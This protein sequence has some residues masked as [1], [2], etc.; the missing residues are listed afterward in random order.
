MLRKRSGFTLIELLVVIAIIAILIAL[1]VPAVQKV[2]EAAARTQCT[3]N[4]KQMGL[5]A[6]SCH[7]AY[8]HFPPAL[9]TMGSSSVPVANQAW[10]NAIFHMLPFIDQGNLYQQSFGTVAAFGFSCY[11]A[12]NNNVYAQVV[13]VF[14]CPSDPSQ[15]GGQVTFTINGTAYQFGACSYGFNSLIFSGNNNITY[16]VPP[17]QP[18]LVTANGYNP[19]GA[20][21]MIQITDGTSNTILMAERYSTC[22]NATYSAL[23]LSGGSVWAYCSDPNSPMSNVTGAMKPASVAGNAAPEMLFPGIEVAYFLEGAAL[24]PPITTPLANCV[25]TASIFQVQPHPFQTNC[26]PVRAAT[27]HTGIMQDCL[28]D[29]SV[30]TVSGSI[31]PTTWWYACTPAGGEVLGGDWNQ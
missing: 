18:A 21:T 9:G 1:L 16:P 3:N 25:G 28:V 31:S 23:G 6:Q 12:G 27:P 4:L 10:G 8:K 14:V 11:Y 15:S 29:G 13:P 30:R 2:R 22:S 26:D 7:D 19:Q 17:A 5:A 20:T 24:A